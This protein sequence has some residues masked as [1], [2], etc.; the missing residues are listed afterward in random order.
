MGAMRRTVQFTKGGLLGAA[1]GVGAAI[2]LTPGSGD[3]L[4]AGLR[5]RV[6]GAKA[7]GEAARATTER[8]LIAKYRGD[9]SDPTALAE[10]P[11]AP[12]APLRA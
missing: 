9:V 11:A 2:L 6:R 7:A 5:D 3:D 12:P 10:E 8:E 1:I 4:R